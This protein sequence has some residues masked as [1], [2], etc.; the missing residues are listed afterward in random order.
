MT[1]ASGFQGRGRNPS[2][3]ASGDKSAPAIRKTQPLRPVSIKMLFDAMH[4]ADGALVV[5][6]REIGQVVIVGRVLDHEGASNNKAM[7]AKFHGYVVSDC[8]GV[9]VVRNWL[10]ASGDTAQTPIPKGAHLRAVGTVK[11]FNDKPMI[12]GQVTEITS[13]NELWYHNL[14]V[15]L[16]HYRITSGPC[17]LAAATGGA[18]KAQT[19]TFSLPPGTSIADALLGLIKKVKPVGLDKLLALCSPTLDQSQI[20]SGLKKLQDEGKIFDNGGGQWTV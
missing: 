15:V 8:S 2:G 19:S 7:T 12:T 16:T 3:G 20:S 4:V 5:D 14:D 18:A 17:D 9:I 11:M 6:G 1:D 10:D 13:T